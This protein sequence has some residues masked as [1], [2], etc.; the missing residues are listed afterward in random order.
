MLD[1]KSI[2][3]KALNENKSLSNKSVILSQI[4]HFMYFLN[5]I[6]IKN[7]STTIYDPQTSA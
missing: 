4:V 6:V 7:E 3:K 5:S 1:L 2:S